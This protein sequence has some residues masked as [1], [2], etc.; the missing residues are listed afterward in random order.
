M[1]A[2]I[3]QQLMDTNRN[4]HINIIQ[5]RRSGQNYYTTKTPWIFREKSITNNIATTQKLIQ[6]Q[7]GNI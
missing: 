3:T 5:E 1:K 7:I 2:L 4:I 6:W